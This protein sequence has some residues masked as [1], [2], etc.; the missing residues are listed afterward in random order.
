MVGMTRVLV[1]AFEP[2]GGDAVNASGEAVA[3]LAASWA[4]PTVE[5]VKEILPVS[6]ERAPL[7][8]ADAIRGHRPDAVVCIGEAGGRVAVTP[9]RHAVNERVARIAD[10]DGAMLDGPIDGGPDV[11]ETRLDVAGIV[12]A[13]RSLG[14]PAEGSEDAGRFVC[15][16]VFRS[17]LT[18]F[19]GPAGFI[20]VPAVRDVGEATVGAET[21]AAAGRRSLEMTFEDLALALDA[22]VRCVAVGLEHR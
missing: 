11:L 6:F 19:D 12:A 15:N 22:V 14:V 20:H 10:N 13:V 7:A 5:L 21:D 2:F 1:T 4:D 17:V 9:E 8:L 16:T 18:L 3:R